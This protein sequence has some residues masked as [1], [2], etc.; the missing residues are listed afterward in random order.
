[1]KISSIPFCTTDWSAIQSTEHPGDTGKA[2]WRTLQLGDI[3]VRLVEYTPGYVANH[4]CARGH[5]L[6]VLEG[7]LLTELKDGRRFELGPMMSYQ[8]ADADGEHRSST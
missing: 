3:R 2:F 5:I 7:T 4:W 6:L 8:V 1:M